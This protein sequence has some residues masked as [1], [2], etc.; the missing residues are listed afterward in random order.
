MSMITCIIV[1]DEPLAA[2]MLTGYIADVPFLELRGTF[3]DAVYANAYLQ[4]HPV[5]LIFLDLHLPKMKGFA[6]LRSLSHPPSVIVT[7]AYHHYAVEGFNLNVTDYLLK[8][9]DFGRFMVAVNKVKGALRERRQA[10]E[11]REPKDHIFLSVKNKKVKVPFSDIL[12]VESQR[13]YVRV[14]T[15][16]NEYVS[17]ISTREIER[18]LPGHLFK[19]IHRS[20]IISVNRIS[21]FTAEKVEVG[22]VSIPVGRAYRSVI[23]DF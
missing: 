17:K 18:I 15:Q 8:P 22:G 23:D 5:D 21:S 13:E 4:E 20:F 19:R 12:Y 6:F 3:K 16:M 11:C 9:F 2:K 7:T 10:A 1:E 14:V